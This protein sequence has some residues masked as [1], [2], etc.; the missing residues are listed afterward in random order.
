MGTGGVPGN[1]PAATTMPPEQRF[2]QQL[3]QL[4]SMGFVDRQANIQGMQFYNISTV[5]ALS[6]K[7]HLL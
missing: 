3:E 6:T 2:A 7:K 1:S 4:A 5:F